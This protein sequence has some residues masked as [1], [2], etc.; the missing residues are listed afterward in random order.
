METL[1]LLNKLSEHFN[2]ILMKS[3]PP[4]MA[5]FDAAANCTWPW[6][7][8]INRFSSKYAENIKHSSSWQSVILIVTVA[9]SPCCL[10]FLCRSI[11]RTLVQK[12]AQAFDVFLTKSKRARHICVAVFFAARE[13]A[14]EAQGAAEREHFDGLLNFRTYNRWRRRMRREKYDENKNR[15][16]NA[17][18]QRT[19]ERPKVPDD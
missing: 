13:T 9:A 15:S 10:L 7:L 11:H 19:T 18:V 16:E 3:V 1:K 8:S 2:F 14:G 17:G 4:T 12:W 5:P 6:L